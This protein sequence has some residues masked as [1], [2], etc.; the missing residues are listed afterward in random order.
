MNMEQIGKLLEIVG[1]IIATGI[2]GIFLEKRVL[3]IWGNKSEAFFKWLVNIANKT[4]LPSGHAKLLMYDIRVPNEQSLNML[5]IRTFGKLL[6]ISVL[7]AILPGSITISITGLLLNINWMLRLGIGLLSV[8]II[9]M[10]ITI[11]LEWAKTKEHRKTGQAEDIRTVADNSK[12]RLS[13]KQIGKATGIILLVIVLIPVILILLQTVSLLVISV[14]L[15]MG[16]IRI[17][18]TLATY[19]AQEDKLRRALIISGAG[20]ILA[21]LI[22]EYIAMP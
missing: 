5:N 16:V 7:I 4:Q 19:L 20:M 15:L 22:L 6:L 14:T 11:L 3:G 2:A 17:L 18:Q 8:Y 12:R 13:L 1:F 10:V 9:V 21:G